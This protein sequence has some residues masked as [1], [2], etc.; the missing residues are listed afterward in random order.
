MKDEATT[1]VY[2]Y[3]YVY[4]CVKCG[5]QNSIMRHN[6]VYARY[7]YDRVCTRIIGIRY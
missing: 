7:A 6:V 2:I 4:M 5:M 1:Y 3:I